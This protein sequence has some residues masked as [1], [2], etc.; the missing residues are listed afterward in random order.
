MKT[1]E[2]IQNA[3]EKLKEVKPLVRR[4]TYFGDDNWAQIDAQ[5]AVLERG[6]TEDD[7]YDRYDDPNILNSAQVAY[8]WVM[9]L[10]IEDLEE[11]IETLADIW[12]ELK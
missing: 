10:P 9:D 5:I 1:K 11:E 4:Y 3:V 7:I 6:Y 8:Q 12:N 2:Q